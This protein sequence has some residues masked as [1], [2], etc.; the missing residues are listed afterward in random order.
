MKSALTVV[1]L[2]LFAFST[3]AFAMGGCHKACADGYTYSKESGA[4]V[5][6]TVSS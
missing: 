5:K 2:S 3:S 1:A 4:C 6:K